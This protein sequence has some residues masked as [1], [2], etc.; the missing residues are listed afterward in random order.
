MESCLVTMINPFSKE[1]R[2][3]TC[4][5]MSFG[6]AIFWCLEK[7]GNSNWWYT[8]INCYLIFECVLRDNRTW[9]WMQK[10]LY[11]LEHKTIC[12]TLTS[13]QANIYEWGRASLSNLRKFFYF[14]Y[15]KNWKGE[16]MQVP[17][18]MI[19]NDMRMRH[20]SWRYN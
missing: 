10:I 2:V 14:G 8:I 19:C 16:N 17:N 18:N 3:S 5:W 15:L 6:F 7:D 11:L 13:G 4:T 12:E 20:P 9:S 1:F